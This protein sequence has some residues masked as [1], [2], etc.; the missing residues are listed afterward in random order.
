MANWLIKHDI[1]SIVTICLS[2]RNTCLFVLQEKNH[3]P[4]SFTSNETVCLTPSL[5]KCWVY[6][7]VRTCDT[8]SLFRTFCFSRFYCAV[9]TREF[10]RFLHRGWANLFSSRRSAWSVKC[11]QGSE[12]FAEF[13]GTFCTL[14]V[15]RQ[16]Y[17]ARSLILLI[18]SVRF[19]VS[20]FESFLGFWEFFPR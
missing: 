7:G 3:L 19:L 18:I 17:P 9:L 14:W 4:H 1:K 11:N 16:W 20:T 8:F 5:A 13:S 6:L 2:R 12:V 10:N 15:V